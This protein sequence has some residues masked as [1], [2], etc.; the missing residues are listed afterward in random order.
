MVVYTDT[1]L[2]TLREKVSTIG[3][4]KLEPQT[5]ARHFFHKWK[6][7]KNLPPFPAN[8]FLWRKTFKE[9]R[10]GDSKWPFDPWVGGH[11]TF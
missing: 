8:Y 5:V 3:G 4:F 11:L 2:P 6:S 10:P 1:I 7:E 9:K